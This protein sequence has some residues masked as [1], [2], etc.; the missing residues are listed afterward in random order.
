MN[1]SIFW[2]LVWKE[3]R[4]QRALWIA[5][6]VLTFLLQGIVVGTVASSVDRVNYLFGFALT[7]TACYA[8][9]CGAVLFA[10]ERETG[11][12]EFQRV[13]PVSSLRLFAAKVTFAL[14][15]TSALILALFLSAAWLSGWRLPDAQT[16]LALWAVL[17]LGALEVLTWGI[18]FSLLSAHPLFAAILGI[19]VASTVVHLSAPNALSLSH[20]P[21]YLPTVPLRAVILAL[22]ALADFWLGLRWLRATSEVSLSERLAVRRPTFASQAAALPAVPRPPRGMMLARLLWQQWRQSRGMMAVPVLLAVVFGSLIAWHARVGFIWSLNWLQTATILASLLAALMG[23]CVFLGDQS[24]QRYRFFAEH[25][26]RPGSVWL[27]RQLVWIIPMM[28]F[29]TA[30]ALLD[31]TGRGQVRQ[32][33]VSSLSNPWLRQIRLGP[34]PLVH[35]GRR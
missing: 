24:R 13:L 14:A 17:G 29:I 15:S 9:G 2:R 27:T 6:A 34:R 25:A 10:A 1:R 30:A 21:S 12:F 22:V 32:L 7:M 28:L 33:A 23:S 4:L 11:T 31:R 20:L 26:A 19:S 16:H 18:F 5:I 8:M 3:Y 35:K